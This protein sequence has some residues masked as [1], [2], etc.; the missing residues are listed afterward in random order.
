MLLVEVMRSEP[1]IGAAE[2]DAVIAALRDKVGLAGDEIDRLVE[3]AEQ[4]SRTATDHFA[5]TSKINED[6]AMGQ[7]VRMSERMWRM[8][9]ADGHLGAHENRVMT[10]VADLLY[11]PHGDYVAA[12]MRARQG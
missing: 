4:A 12:K 9:Y 1:D 3:L 11:I 5:F 2:R 8:A 7:K 6:F 10:T